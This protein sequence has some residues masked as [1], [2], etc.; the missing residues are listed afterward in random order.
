MRAGDSVAKRPRATL[1]GLPSEGPASVSVVLV[2]LVV[3]VLPALWAEAGAVGAAEDLVREREGDG[4]PGPG[5]EVEAV[6]DEIRRA[7]LVVVRGGGLV[8]ARVD[9]DVERG[10]AETAVARPV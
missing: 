6:V 9:R 8:L 3:Q 4:V 5:R 2:R 1:R 7:E 10:V